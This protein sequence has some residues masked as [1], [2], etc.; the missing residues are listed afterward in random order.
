MQHAT[1][2]IAS[3]RVYLQ[4][5][6]FFAIFCI[7]LYL[8]F[9]NYSNTFDMGW[10]QARDGW[11]VR[12]ILHGT[13]VTNGPRT[14]VG[15]FHLA[16][17]WYYFLTPFY[18]LT[19]LDPVASLY[20][21]VLVGIVN[22]L[23]FY[24][25][26]KRIFGTV[27]AL[28]ALYILATNDY[29]IE[30]MRIPWNV[31]PVL[32]VSSLI[33]YCIHE[34]VFHE[35]YRY[36]FLLSA[37]TGFFINL[38]FGFV[39]LPP[40]ILAS[41]LCMKHRIRFVKY[42]LYSIPIFIIWF[43]PLVLLDIE[44]KGGNTGLL[45]NLFSDYLIHG[46]HLQF[47]LHRLHDAFIMFEKIFI[48]HHAIAWGKFVPMLVVGLFSLRDSMKNRKMNYLLSLWFFVPS[49]I[50]AFYGGSTSEYYMLLSAPMVIYMMLYMQ[51][52]VFAI[53][54]RYKF[55]KFGLVLITIAWLLYGLRGAEGKWLRKAYGGLNE[56]RDQVYRMYKGGG[57]I[58]YNEGDPK[59][60]L[61]QVIR[62]A[63]T[64]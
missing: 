14:G 22:F 59:A 58:E 40:I 39:F 64:K 46:F 63:N 33:F 13:L 5:I 32:G 20:A 27:S 26:T 53:F 41:M 28:L 4:P 2:R 44:W 36:T 43:I 37:L 23:L 9:W 31:S 15:H 16:P 17:L 34:I 8:R 10:D 6:L 51:K 54:Q 35:R 1:S 24:W 57:T 48:I 3:Y 49:I 7:G 38:H 19:R 60:Y 62:D 30:I 18:F 50:Y 42:G 55:R 47:Y 56:Q 11:K 25:V 61:M 45:K 52:R 29:L 12:D 21:N